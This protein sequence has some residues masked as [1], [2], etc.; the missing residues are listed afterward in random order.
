MTGRRPSARPR[1]PREDSVSP[2]FPPDLHFDVPSGDSSESEPGPA[3][4]QRPDGATNHPAGLTAQ[5]EA[6]FGGPAGRET[7]IR[8]RAIEREREEVSGALH[9]STLFFL[10]CARY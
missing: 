3:R 6:M 4:R 1:V 7:R 5:A 2:P 8:Q 10:C 9:Y